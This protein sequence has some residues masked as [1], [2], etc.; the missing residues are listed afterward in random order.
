MKKKQVLVAIF[1]VL[2]AGPHLQAQ[3]VFSDAFKKTVAK[4]LKNKVQNG[5]IHW[6]TDA[7]PVIGIVGRD[8]IGQV[9]NSAHPDELIRSVTNVVTTSVF[10]YN[11]QDILKTSVPDSIY[12]HVLQEA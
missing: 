5:V 1:I 3:A 8:L 12:Q 11:V 9:I 10:I 7:E 4:I 2:F 6:L